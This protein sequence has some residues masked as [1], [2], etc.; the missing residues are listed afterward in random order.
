MAWYWSALACLL[1]LLAGAGAGAWVMHLRSKRKRLLGGRRMIRPL[2]ERHFR[3]LPLDKLTIAERRFPFRVRADLQKAIDRLFSA[4]TAVHHFCGVRKEYARGGLQFGDLLIDGHSPAASVPPEY[5]EVDI[6]E[7]EPV[8]CLKCGLWLLEEAGCRFAVLLSQASQ[9][10]G[11]PTGM[12]FQVATP[13]DLGGNRI[14]QAFFR[15]LEESVLRAE[16]YRGKVLSLEQSD[17]SYSGES[18]G[19]AVHRLPAVAREQVI[20]PAT[21]LDLL[22]RNVIQFVRQRRRRLSQ[23]GL[24]AK[25]GLLFYGPPGTGK[26]LTVRYLAGALEG[27]T[28]LLVTAEQLGLLGEYMTL[29]RLLQPTIV[30]LEDVDLIARERSELRS[31]CQES[32]L[33]RLLNEMDGLKEDA[34]VLFILTTNRPEALEA[35][36]ASRPGRVDQAIEF[37]L[38]DEEGREKLVRL[39]SAGVE[40]EEGV[41][42]RVVERTGLV[43][44]AFI[45]ELMRRTLQYHLERGGP[46]RVEWEDVER[47]LDKML[48]KGGSLNLKLLG[49]EGANGVG[50]GFGRNSRHR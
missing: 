16:S 9:G 28:T 1:S 24:S 30:V 32:L 6:G 8:P 34:D 37:P 27:H 26:T 20:L 47:A 13:N 35:A 46:G 33:N 49:A 42:G 31:P 22:E 11:D 38:P 45:K 29:A 41:V 15:H 19:I 4:T 23:F 44:A 14:S 39:Y 12:R 43:S 10:Y 5:E 18:S 3:P 2:L 36:L 7:N 17:S 25:K 40:L 21:T 48:F 50:V